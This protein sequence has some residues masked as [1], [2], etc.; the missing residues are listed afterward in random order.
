MLLL[1]SFFTQSYEEN[2]C[3][4]DRLRDKMSKRERERERERK[5]QRG[6]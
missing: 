1:A 5:W 3:G 2:Y 4:C 6:I